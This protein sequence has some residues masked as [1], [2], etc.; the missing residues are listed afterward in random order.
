MKEQPA[1]TTPSPAP[2]GCTPQ[3]LNPPDT[4]RVFSSVY[5]QN[6]AGT[7]YARSMIN[8]GAAWSAATSDQN[9][10]MYI[11]LGKVYYIE[12]FQVQERADDP[13]QYITEVEVALS[14]NTHSWE[15]VGTFTTQ[16][17]KLTNHQ[18][19]GTARYVEFMPKAWSGHISMRAGVFTCGEAPVTCLESVLDPPENSRRY[20]SAY[21]NEAAGTGHARSML[22]SVQAWSPYSTGGAWMEIVL[23]DTMDLV[24]VK[25]LPRHDKPWQYVTKFK[26]QLS[27]DGISYSDAGEYQSATGAFHVYLHSNKQSAPARYVKFLPLTWHSHP[28]MRAGLLLCGS[29]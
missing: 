7:G 28:S 29:R 4:S 2:V 1:T 19:S 27:T 12:G 8:S 21:Y 18:V 9:Q 26:L 11:D 14:N 6:P 3:L 20:S 10:Y 22:N 15:S 24:G 13:S 23:S 16:L 25:V 17:G 5:G